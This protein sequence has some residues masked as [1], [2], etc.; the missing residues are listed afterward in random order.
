MDANVGWRRLERSAI[1]MVASAAAACGPVKPH[2]AAP[3]AAPADLLSLVFKRVDEWQFV[4]L[5]A[6]LT[7]VEQQLKRQFERVFTNAQHSHP[8][9]CF[10][11]EQASFYEKHAALPD[12]N[13]G[14]EMLGRCGAPSAGRLGFRI[15]H[16]DGTLLDSPL[17]DANLSDMSQ[18]L[19]D[20]L[21]PFTTFGVTARPFGPNALVMIHTASPEATIHVGEPDE[22]RNVLVQGEVL[23]DFDRAFATINQGISRTASCEPDDVPWPQYRFRCPMAAGDAEAWITLSATADESWETS[24]LHVSAHRAGWTPPAGYRRAILDLPA[25]VDTR[26]ALLVTI[27][28]LRAQQGKHAL[29]FAAEQSHFMAPL[30][31]RMFRTW[32]EDNFALQAQLIRGERVRGHV[33]WGGI[34][35]GIAFDGDATDWLTWHLKHPLSRAT[36]MSDIADQLALTTHG[37]PS[38]GFGGAAVVYRVLTPERDSALSDAL[39]AS[40]SK[41]RGKRATKRVESP[42]ELEA[43]VDEIAQGAEPATALDAALRRANLATMRSHYLAGAFLPLPAKGLDSLPSTLRDPQELT[44]GIV[45]V[46]VNDAASGW[47]TPVAVVWF[48]SEPPPGSLALH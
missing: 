38:V 22:A 30:Y 41:L 25:Q 17:S 5:D 21:P 40:I 35:A 11:R 39:A 37:E 7:S 20:G 14:M 31:E 10:A 42:P 34:A 23:S 48:H 46:H 26:K 45:V 27:N 9:Q 19:V 24:L 6:P 29:E 1:F 32:F 3:E 44:Y 2:A 28:D 16:S 15:Y 36:F 8:Y 33:S 47:Y 4:D 13:L 12:Q 43:L 18:K